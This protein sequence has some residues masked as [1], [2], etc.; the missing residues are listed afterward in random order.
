MQRL[1]RY[2]Y[3]GVTLPLRGWAK[4]LGAAE[5][6][7][8]ARLIGGWS[9]EKTLGT[10]IA[11]WERPRDQEAKYRPPRTSYILEGDGRFMTVKE[12]AAELGCANHIIYYCI[13]YNRP[14]KRR[15]GKSITF[16]R[17][18]A[19]EHGGVALRACE[20]ADRLGITC[21]AFLRRI[22]DGLGEAD[23]FRDS[24]ET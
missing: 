12:W 10:P 1:T 22:S 14:F 23:V 11:P 17:H 16:T 4:R 18:Q 24:N 8:E 21:E 19:F 7:L 5:A 3:N 15:D 2:M 20:W 13:R 6:A 9:V